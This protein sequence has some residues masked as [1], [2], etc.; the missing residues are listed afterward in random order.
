MSANIRYKSSAR[1][2]SLVE[3]S[4]VVLIIATLLAGILVAKSL[5]DK[6]KI[7]KARTL[8][9]SSAIVGTKD[10]TLWLENS[11]PESVAADLEDGSDVTGWFAYDSTSSPSNNATSSGVAGKDPT[12]VKSSDSSVPGIKFSAGQYLIAPTSM[13]S[14]FKGNYTLL[15]VENSTI[16]TSHNYFIQIDK[17]AGGIDSIGYEDA[18]TIRFFDQKADITGVAAGNRVHVFSSN[19][20]VLSYSLNGQSKSLTAFSSLEGLEHPK[21][22][23]TLPND[24]RLSNSD[25]IKHY[26]QNLRSSFSHKVQAVQN[27]IYLGDKT[28]TGGGQTI[29]KEVVAIA[30]NLSQSNLDAAVGY[31]LNKQVTGNKS[32]QS[33]QATNSCA[34]VQCQNGGSCNNGLCTCP[35]GYTGTNCT[36]PSCSPTPC[37]NSGTCAISGSTY[38]CTCTAGYT[39]ANCQTACSPACLNGGTCTTNNGNAVCSCPAGFSGPDCGTADCS[40]NTARA[41]CLAHKLAGCN[42]SGAYKIAFSG[43]SFQTYCDMDSTHAGGGWTMVAALFENTVVGTG[44]DW[45]GGINEATFT[46]PTTAQL[47]SSPSN[48]PIFALNSGQLPTHTQVAFGGRA[49]VAGSTFNASYT[50]YTNATYTTGDIALTTVK[51]F[52]TSEDF[53]LVRNSASVYAYQDPDYAPGSPG[54]VWAKALI[55]DKKGLQQSFSWAFVPVGDSSSARIHSFDANNRYGILD[56]YALTVSV[57]NLAGKKLSGGVIVNCAQ[58]EAYNVNTGNCYCP[59]GLPNG[60][61]GCS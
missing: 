47:I 39:G 44:F 51:N 49:G 19:G 21:L 30:G 48:A 26:L 50:G 17:G 5:I 38:T 37:Q 34:S 24:N 56:N 40:I 6:A 16:G 53:W 57:R 54:G 41:D 1:A 55:F 13:D 33:G 18:N 29:M 59:S 8:T 52:A 15:L 2:F 11:M 22:A 9:R 10:L 45:N 12:F 3:L 25:A 4:I 20:G 61:G 58:N 14:L 31:L 27:I 23:F 42:T 43:H 35:A 7:T 36:T 32:T 28:T 60:N 46:P